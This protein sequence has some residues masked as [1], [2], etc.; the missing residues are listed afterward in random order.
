V[1]TPGGTPV[2]LPV[3]NQDDPPAAA[4]T[5]ATPT[6]TTTARPRAGW[7]ATGPRTT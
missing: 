4:T 2:P 3:S 1:V 6:T 5:T 7:T